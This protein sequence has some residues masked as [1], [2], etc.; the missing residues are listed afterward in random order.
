MIR[1]LKFR[2]GVVFDVFQHPKKFALDFQFRT[3]SGSREGGEARASQLTPTA[4]FPFLV[5]LAHRHF[6]LSSSTRE[7][8]E[9]SLQEMAS[10]RRREHRQGPDAEAVEEDEAQY[11]RGGMSLE[12]VDQHFPHRPKN[13]HKTLPFAE[14]YKSLFNPLM[15]CKPGSSA[16]AG[17]AAAAVPGKTRFGKAKK[18]TGGVNYH[19]QRRHIIERFMSQWRKEVGDDFYPAMRLILPD[20]DRDRGVYGLKES[21]IGKMLVRRFTGIAVRRR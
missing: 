4:L 1:A 20:K 9:E 12:E 3:W 15:D 6:I 13:A 16:A 11:G 14:L 5:N 8:L 18:K 10:Q 2:S 7:T 19:E 21:G 17:A